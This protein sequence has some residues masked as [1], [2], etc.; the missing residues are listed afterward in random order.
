MC[1]EGVDGS[2]GLCN[3][4]MMAKPN[5]QFLQR[6]YA[7]YSS[8]DSSQWNYRSVVLPAKLAPFQRRDY[9]PRL[10]SILVDIMGFSWIMHIIFGK[11][12]R[13]F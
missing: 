13:L 1:Q 11:D 3:A 5:A 7:T 4:M 10:Q 2:S 8:F 12:L 9:G 6:Y